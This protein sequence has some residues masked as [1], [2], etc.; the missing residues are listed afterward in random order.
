MIVMPESF[1]GKKPFKTISVWDLILLLEYII[2]LIKGFK[3]HYFMSIFTRLC[4]K[5]C[6]YQIIYY[7][8]FSKDLDP[9]TIIQM[10]NYRREKAIWASHS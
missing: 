9:K 2:S 5:L 1:L 7:F 10:E 8:Y 4:K 3:F 6:H